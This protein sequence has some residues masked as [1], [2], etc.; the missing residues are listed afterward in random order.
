[1]MGEYCYWLKRDRDTAHNRMSQ[2]RVS[3]HL[4]LMFFD[5]YLPF[6]LSKPNV[7]TVVWL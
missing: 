2:K 3:F 1:M 7:N 4:F 5:I 6:T